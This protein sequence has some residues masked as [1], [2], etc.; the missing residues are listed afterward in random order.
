VV[1]PSERW[2]LVG[3]E[4]ART[5]RIAAHEKAKRRHDRPLRSIAFAAGWGRVCSTPGSPPLAGRAFP[6]IRA[7][8]IRRGV[9]RKRL[10]PPPSQAPINPLD[11]PLDT[12]LG[13]LTYALT[14]T[15]PGRSVFGEIN[16][17]ACFTT[18][19]DSVRKPFRH[20]AFRGR[21]IPAARVIVLK[22]AWSVVQCVGNRRPVFVV[23]RQRTGR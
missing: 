3:V 4:I 12:R 6:V 20:G 23:F 8:V 2:D 5:P 19:I 11:T 18:R 16:V 9:A 22:S 10:A 15:R 21:D 14:Q 17:G 7:V 1:T 13:A